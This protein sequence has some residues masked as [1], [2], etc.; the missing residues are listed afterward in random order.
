MKRA[1]ISLVLVLAL[2]ACDGPSFEPASIVLGPRV[3]AIV[4]EPAETVPGVDITLVP[5][6]A[7]PHDEV[8]SF[9]WSA[10]LSTE[11]L[12]AS[13]GQPLGEPADLTRLD[14]DGERAT[15]SGSDTRAALDALFALIDGAPAGTPEHVVR[16]VYDE[17]GLTVPVR[18]VMRGADGAILLEGQKRVVFSPR[19]TPSTNP[20]P[21]R[22]ALG[23][24]WVSARDGDPFA[25]VPEGEAPTVTA[26]EVLTLSPD[27]DE[28]WLE[29][30][31][32]L[33]LDGR[34]VEGTEAA[35]YSWFSTGGDF[36][37]DVTR[38]P[39]REGEWTAPDE[40]TVLPIWLVVRD[41]HLGTSACRAEV[42][43]NAR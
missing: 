11:A 41:G 4:A 20:P 10:D 17:V 12:A 9:E 6:V 21:P 25:C 28:S 42:V 1:A 18:F 14:W 40:P 36:V 33:D 26:G 5:L 31:P 3:L 38:V 32:S 30:F 15:L 27:P 24:R 37:F 39:N 13:A 34:R 8:V 29:T 23:G 43:V 22:F 35:Y 2:A 19:A 16:F 7:L